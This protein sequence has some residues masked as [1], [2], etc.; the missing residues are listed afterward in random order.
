MWKLLDIIANVIAMILEI[1]LVI[2]EW[3]VSISSLILCLPCLIVLIIVFFC[4]TI[5]L[6]YERGFK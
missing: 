4:T 5:I 2:F 6:F 3:A 1:I